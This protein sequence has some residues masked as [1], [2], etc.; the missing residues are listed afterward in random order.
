MVA[1]VQL[2]RRIDLKH[3]FQAGHTF[4]TYDN[5]TSKFAE[6]V[7]LYRPATSTTARI[8]SSGKMMCFGAITDEGARLAARIFA[9]AV[10]NMG[11]PL[12]I[13]LILPCY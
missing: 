8:F 6:V 2:G 13:T 1:K 5:K 3:L 11:H 4:A 9:R 7:T 10:Q 12:N